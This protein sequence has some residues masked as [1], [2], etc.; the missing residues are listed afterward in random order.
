MVHPTQRIQVWVDIDVGIVALVQRLN[1]IPGVMTHT[2]CQ[3][4]IGEG[5]A[6]PYV[7]YVRVTWDDDATLTA[8]RAEF[9]VELIGENYGIVTLHPP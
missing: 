3:G 8:L 7:G 2:S 9:E 6:E 1:W 5:G 4:T